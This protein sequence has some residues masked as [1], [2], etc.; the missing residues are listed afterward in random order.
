MQLLTHRFNSFFSI[1]VFKKPL[2]LRCFKENIMRTLLFCAFLVQS[3]FASVIPEIVHSF[4]IGDS[5]DNDFSILIKSKSDS[6][7]IYVKYQALQRASNRSPYVDTITIF[8]NYTDT[9]SA[10][11]DK[12]KTKSNGKFSIR[13]LFTQMFSGDDCKVDLNITKDTIFKMREVT[14]EIHSNDWQAFS[15][16][17][18]AIHKSSFLSYVDNQTKIGHAFLSCDDSVNYVVAD[19]SHEQLIGEMQLFETGKKQASATYRFPFMKASVLCGNYRENIEYEM[20]VSEDEIRLDAKIDAL[21]STG[22]N[23]IISGRF[24]LNG[25][26]FSVSKEIPLS[27]SIRSCDQFKL[28]RVCWDIKHANHFRK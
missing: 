27:S 7:S 11:F 23:L 12:P 13:C 2:N 6:A 22:Q 25:L 17:I 20:H 9:I 28:G 1:N 18:K 19:S 10:K 15:E 14:I 21:P 3:P 4:V 16:K 8:R 26:Y 24:I 5:V